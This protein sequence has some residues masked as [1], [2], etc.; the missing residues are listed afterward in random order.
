MFTCLLSNS[1]KLKLPE[2]TA[3]VYKV[4][5]HYQ[6]LAEYLELGDIWPGF[7]ERL[8]CI[9]DQIA[10]C[11]T[12]STQSVLD[13]IACEEDMEHEGSFASSYLGSWGLGPGP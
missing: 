5:L 2:Y 11:L 13:A 6:H 12:Y 1:E 7:F 9:I 8:T 3:F 10:F 4:S